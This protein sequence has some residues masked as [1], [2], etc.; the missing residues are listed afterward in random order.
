VK[1]RTNGFD[2]WVYHKQD[3]KPKYLLFHT[4]Q[5]KAEKWFHGGRFWQI[6]GGFV[7][8]EEEL[9]A[10]F[11]R[12]LHCIGLEAIGIW[13]CE[14]TYIYYNARRKNIEITPVFAAE[15]VEP[16]AI[17]LSWEHSEY[18]WFT[19]DECLERIHFR[20]LIEGLKW[21]R[22]YISEVEAPPENLRF[23]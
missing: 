5:E 19:N 21:T 8:E 17:P 14:H 15:V 20:G 12:V 22:H 6:C 18:G 10:A 3:A 13:A 9:E 23:V 2:L 11:L 16:K 7:G 1:L 4:S